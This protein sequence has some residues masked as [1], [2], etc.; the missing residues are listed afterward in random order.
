[1]IKLDKMT[2]TKVNTWL[3]SE[4]LKK[5]F[6]N[7]NWVDPQSKDDILVKNPATNEVIT[8]V[9]AANESDVQKVVIAA[10]EAFDQGEWQKTSAHERS[11][12]L[13]QI[14]E[15][16]E[17]HADELALIETLNNG[18]TLKESKSD[19]Q[20]AADTF[21]YYA[22]IA[23]M[24]LGERLQVEEPFTSKVVREPVGVCGQIIPWNY[25]LLMAAWKLAPALAAGNT[26]ILK[27][28]EIS[29]LNSNRLFEII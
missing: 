2:H 11:S 24:P 20:S 15:Q 23:L 7:G 12:L 3:K 19:V 10:R 27:T 17:Y 18:K 21:K 25:P 6:I 13:H 4:N 1:M 29:P 28:S 26:F 8:T 16:I 9:G 5:L 22:S 14:A